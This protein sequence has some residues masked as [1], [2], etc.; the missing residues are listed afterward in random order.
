MGIVL[1]L[2]LSI[3]CSTEVS[4]ALNIPKGLSSADQ[5]DV[6]K[7]LGLGTA[8]KM[9][10]NPYP[11]GGYSGFEIGIDRNFLNIDQLTRLG[12]EPGSSGCAN[13]SRSEAQEFSYT[14]ITL[15]KGL[16]ENADLFVSFAPFVSA[17]EQSDFGG[18]L[19]WTFYE[20]KLLPIH[21]LLLV[22]GNYV[23]FKNEFTSKNLSADLLVGINVDDLSIY[24]GGGQTRS[25]GRFIAGIIDDGTINPGSPGIDPGT[26]VSSKLIHRFHTMVG[27]S[28]E[29]SPLFIAGEINRY[30][31]SVY[32]LKVGL[33]Y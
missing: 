18:S 3:V 21:L 24:F 20:A 7:I 10:T 30:E 29:F 19:R 33:R 27:A 6:V 2:L 17:G 23:N 22:S 32:T 11:L 31:D 8:M 9:A 15:G 26:N 28:L 14:K 16:F 5:E 12:C 13:T 4:V 1:G 25:E